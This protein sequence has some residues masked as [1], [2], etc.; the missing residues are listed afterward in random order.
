MT[1]RSRLLKTAFRK[2]GL[3]AFQNLVELT[4]LEP[5]TFCLQSRCSPN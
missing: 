1:D 5:V 4:G 2:S 3:T